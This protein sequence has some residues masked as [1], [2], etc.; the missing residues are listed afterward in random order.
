MR[1]HFVTFYSPGTFFCEQTVKEIDA[2]DVHKATAMARTITERY[3]ATPFAF[4][5]S[6]RERTDNNLDSH[7]IAR[8]GQYYLGGMIETMEDVERRSDPQEHI[9][10]NNMKIN[11]WDKIIVNTNSWKVVRPFTKKDILLNS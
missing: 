11:G 4:V 8:S 5:F 7:E 2:W 6:T 3:G 1:K 10:L 9:L